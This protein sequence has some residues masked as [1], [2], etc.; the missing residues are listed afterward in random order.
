MH[1]SNR[2]VMQTKKKASR[3]CLKYKE[4]TEKTKKAKITSSHITKTT[5]STLH[6]NKEET[7]YI[8][9]TKLCYSKSNDKHSN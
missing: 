1:K 2:I 6:H 4:T 3:M 7:R 8:I 9:I 5:T